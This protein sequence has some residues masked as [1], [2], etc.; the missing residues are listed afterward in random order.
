M[1]FIRAHRAKRFDG[2]LLAQD[3]YFEFYLACAL[4]GAKNLETEISGIVVDGE[5][6]SADFGVVGKGCLHS[7]LCAADIENF[8]VYAPGLQSLHDLISERSESGDS[9]FDV[10]IG[11]SRYKADFSAREVPLDNLSVSLSVK[12]QAVAAVYH[13]S[14]PLKNLLRNLVKSVH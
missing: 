5:L 9:H 14:K 10:G 11:N 12:G 4:A 1:N 7:I 8:G 13:R 3:A 2:D 6:V